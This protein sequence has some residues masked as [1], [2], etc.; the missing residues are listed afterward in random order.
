MTNL[1]E[2]LEILEDSVV[3]GHY[4]EIG[5]TDAQELLEY[6]RKLEADADDDRGVL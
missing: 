4:F 5:P 1:E 3:A 2:T 6:I